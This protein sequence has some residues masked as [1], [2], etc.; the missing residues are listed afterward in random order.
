MIASGW[1]IR[2]GVCALVVGFVCACSGHT[3]NTAATPPLGGHKTGAKGGPTPVKSPSPSSPHHSSGSPS[4]A[5]AT[6]FRP[7]GDI[8]DNTVYVDYRVPKSNAHIKVPE[9]WA[10]STTAGVTRFRSSFNSISIQVVKQPNPPTVAS[11]KQVTIPMLRRSMSNFASAKVS[12]TRRSG[13]HAVLITYLVDSTRDPVTGKV[14]RDAVE[15]FMYW[16][17]G[18]Q[19][20]LTLTGPRSAD[21]VDPWRIVS[22]SLRWR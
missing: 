17:H 6:E 2:V 11:A 14:V 15:R 20:T 12:V 8:P 1:S 7:P 4:N 5:P 9:G 18:Q 13:G 10:R 3:S 19:A 21:N 16:H 22:N